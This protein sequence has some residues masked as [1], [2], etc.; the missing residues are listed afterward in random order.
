M[1]VYEWDIPAGI[2]AALATAAQKMVAD[3]ENFMV[4]RN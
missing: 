1:Y 4:R 3:K 2:A